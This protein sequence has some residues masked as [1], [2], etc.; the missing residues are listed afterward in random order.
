MLIPAHKKLIQIVVTHACPFKCSHC[1]QMVPHQHN[2]NTMSLDEIENALYTL[3]DYPGHIG[4][5][6]GEPTIHPNFEEICKLYQKYIPVKAR[7]ELWTMGYNFDRYRNLIDETFYPEL[8]AYNEHEESQPCWHQPVNIAVDEVFNGEVT[9]C[10]CKDDAIMET[11]INNCWVDRRWSAAITKHGA[12]FCEIAAAR[13]MILGVK[14][15]PVIDGW[16][17]EPESTFKYQKGMCYMCSACLPMEAKPNDS[18]EYDDVSILNN[19]E[20]KI[21]NSPWASNGK[22]HIVSMDKIRDYLRGHKF[23]VEKEYEKRGGFRDFKDW[24]PWIYRPFE[25]KKHRP[26]DVRK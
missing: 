13:A 1:S 17:K 14:G 7:R 5:F 24:H 4:L 25:E 23:K 8:V 10:I 12:F 11:V 19:I 16:W 22:T 2:N 6:G 20:L 21:K 18:Q 3:R 26:E 15:V 9:G